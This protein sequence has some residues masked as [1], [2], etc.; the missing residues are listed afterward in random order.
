VV[1]A[2]PGVRLEPHFER[3]VLDDRLDQL[4]RLVVSLD[5]DRLALPDVDARLHPRRDVHG[6]KRWN[7]AIFAAGDR[8]SRN[9]GKQ[10]GDA[11]G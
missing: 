3:I 5:V 11:H 8:G 1:A 4:Q 7:I 2:Q 9:Q 6:R 10:Q